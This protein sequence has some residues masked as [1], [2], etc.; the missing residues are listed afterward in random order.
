MRRRL[1]ISILVSRRHTDYCKPAQCGCGC[2]QQQLDCGYRGGSATWATER[3]CGGSFTYTPVANFNGGDSFTYKVNDGE[4]DSAV[5]TVTLTI[6]AV[7]DAPVAT[8]AQMTSA[9]DTPLIIDLHSALLMLIARRCPNDG[10]CC[11]T[12]AGCP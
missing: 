2:R 1:P 3:Q 8:D 10:H 7:N 9:E 4:L 6:V 11:A 5:A 12:R